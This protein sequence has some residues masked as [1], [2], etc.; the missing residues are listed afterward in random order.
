MSEP[1]RRKHFQIHLST[2]I[3]MMFVAGL[4]IWANVRRN[5]T[6]TPG[7]TYYSYGWPDPVYYY[8]KATV[9]EA[10]GFGFGAQPFFINAIIAFDALWLVW[11]ISEWLI[12]RHAI[13]IRQPILDESSRL[14]RFPIHVPTVVAMIL[15]TGVLIWA[16]V[17]RDCGDFMT[18]PITVCDCGWPDHFVEFKLDHVTQQSDYI[19]GIQELIIDLVIAINILWLIW[20]TSEWRIRRRAARKAA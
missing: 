11:K 8:A 19:F 14:K 12:R 10:S 4:L 1:P 9:M 3:V 13:R 6:N 16:N 20:K 5:Y 17:R 15:V 18:I 2:A 7:E